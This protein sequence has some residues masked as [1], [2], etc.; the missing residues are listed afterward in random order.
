MGV[1]G[2]SRRYLGIAL[3]SLFATLRS[4][5]DALLANPIES[6]E[7]LATP[8]HTNQLESKIK[9]SNPCKKTLTKSLIFTNQVIGNLSYIIG[10][11]SNAL[12]IAYLSSSPWA[13]WLPGMPIVGLT[14]LY[15]N[16]V[17]WEPI[18]E[19]AYEFIHRLIDPKNSM[20]I[21]AL[22]APMQSLEV[23]IQSLSSAAL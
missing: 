3:A 2:Y 15:F 14:V 21:N 22:R 20:I 10:S 9:K 12:P 16:L 17:N 23:L 7:I 4:G 19:H 6:A 5:S 18:K 8:S 11:F 1:R 13:Q